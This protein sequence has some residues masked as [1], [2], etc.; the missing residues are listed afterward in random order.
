MEIQRIEHV[1][2]NTLDFERSIDFYGRIL[3]FTQRQTVDCGD[4]NITYFEIPGGERLE[5]FDYHGRNP[6]VNHPESATG[7]RHLAFAVRDVTV[8]EQQLR[9]AGVEITLPATDLPDLGVRVLLALDPNGV[10]LEFCEA[11]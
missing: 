1:S 11:L 9:E 6:L 8:H 3:G 10:T 7:L 5:L 4:F 2:I